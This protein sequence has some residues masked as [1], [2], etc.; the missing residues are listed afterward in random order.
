[1]RFEVGGEE[2]E[3]AFDGRTGHGDEIA[4]SFALVEREN[5][6]ELLEDG[7]ASL[8]LLNF[9]QQRR[10]G[11]GFHPAG[12]ALAARFD[13]EK[14]GDFQHLFYDA[15]SFTD[16]AHDTAAQSRA[17]VAHGIMIQGCIDL[18]GWEER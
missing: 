12:G 1:M 5:F 2:L 7:R 9:F 14:F 3:R 15:S 17:G 8:T 13:G 10:K 18:V 11:V 4:K 6:A 16:Q